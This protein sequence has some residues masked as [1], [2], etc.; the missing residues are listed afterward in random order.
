MSPKGKGQGPI[1]LTE[2]EAIAPAGQGTGR[3]RII[4]SSRAGKMRVG[5]ELGRGGE[6]GVLPES[7]LLFATNMKRGGAERPM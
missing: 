2:E 4:A 5:V 3:R 1:A 6:E 7:T